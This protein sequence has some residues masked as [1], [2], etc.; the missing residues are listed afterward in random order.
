MPKIGDILGGKYRLTDLLGVGGM[1]EVYE[2]QHI[3]LTSKKVAI[4]VLRL[5]ETPKADIA[6]RFHRE[7]QVAAAVGHRGVI[8]IY[9]TGTCDDGA[10]YQIMEIL[11]G[12]TLFSRLRLR[13]PIELPVAA[14]ISCQVLSALEAVHSEGVVHRDLKPENIFLVDTGAALPDIK[15]LDFGISHLMPN[16]DL[17]DDSPSL[18]KTGTVI[19]TPRYMSPEQARGRKGLDNRSDVFSMGAIL[20]ACLAGR[21]PFDEKNTYALVL[22]VATEEPP[23]LNS[24]V[25][26]IP[27]E[28]EEIVI[29]ALQ[30][31]PSSRYQSAAQMLKE[32]L[33]FVEPGACSLIPL[34]TPSKEKKR[35]E[36]EWVVAAKQ[37]ERELPA[38]AQAPDVEE[39]VEQEERSEG[40]GEERSKQAYARTVEF[41][42]ASPASAAPAT[43]GKSR[44]RRTILV[45]SLLVALIAVI[46]L[47]A[48]GLW[49]G[50][51]RR[52]ALREVA[53]ERESAG[54]GG[55]T[56]DP[57]PTK[58]HPVA[59]V[60]VGASTDGDASASDNE[61][62]EEGD[63]SSAS[64]SD[65]QLRD[66]P[67]AAKAP[68]RG[69]EPRQRST[70]HPRRTKS[71]PGATKVESSGS[72]KGSEPTQRDYGDYL[73]E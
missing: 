53:D 52:E 47:V 41:E 66:A 73:R 26:D 59:P 67:S 31:D 61:E 56:P 36:P 60:L 32:L 20:Y 69:R 22:Q 70:S 5:E 14:Y 1:G 27:G 42:H 55:T 65:S 54:E 24:L 57:E 19:G 43:A 62:V 33:P 28:V 17:L 50:E 64:E 34:D 16:A 35:P 46:G 29:K 58:S 7:G 3:E 21:P 37:L 6:A 2:A 12:E 68:G 38:T 30:K 23:P 39:P 51:S 8:D 71:T 72:S 45:T 13:G 40:L 48:W 10:P 63:A 18:T 15:L 4:K 11:K 44:G 25:Q 9:D 49:S